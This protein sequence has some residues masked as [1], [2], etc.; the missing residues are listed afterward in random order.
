VDNRVDRY[1]D[2]LRS[3]G[4]QAAYIVA[5]GRSE[6]IA[7]TARGT[8]LRNAGERVL[9]K[10]ATVVER[11]PDEFTSAHPEIEW[12]KIRRMRNLVAHHYDHVDDLLWA[13]L[14]RRIPDLVNTINHLPAA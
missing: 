6:H 8:M 12:A 3:F 14:S 5:Q 9:I 7:A 2:D 11:L 13:A 10:V 4:D 1:L